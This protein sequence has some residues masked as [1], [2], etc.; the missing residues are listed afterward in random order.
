MVEVVESVEGV[1]NVVV[2]VLLIISIVAAFLTLVT[3]LIFRDIR[4]YPIKL[5]LYL[6]VCIMFAFSFFLMA[7]DDTIVKSNFCKGAAVI[8]HFFFIANF[9]WTFCIAFNFYQMIVRRNRESQLLEKWYHLF[10]WGVPS[11]LIVATGASTSYGQISGNESMCYINDDLA[12]FLCFFLPGLIII[13]ANAVLFF[14]IGRE[15]HETL[16]G[17]P[18]SDQRDKKKEF[19]VYISIFISVGLS[20][21]F[22]Y[23]MFIIPNDVAATVFLVLFSIFTPLQGFLIFFSYCVNKKVLAKWAGLFGKCIPCCARWE[24]NLTT[25]TTAP[26]SGS[27]GGASSR[28][29]SSMSS[30]SSAVA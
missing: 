26:S 25:S 12:R 23:L 17:A 8:T 5:I 13:S 2:D 4:T 7:F 20:W 28:S 6:C 15:I 18:K 29:A 30:K 3:F 27:R 14:F 21:V 1:M 24:E 19:R 9:C 11:A 22:G 16:A 10:S